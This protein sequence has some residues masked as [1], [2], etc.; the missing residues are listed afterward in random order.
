MVL[1]S[2]REVLSAKAPPAVSAVLNTIVSF[3]RVTTLSRRRRVEAASDAGGRVVADGDIGEGGSDR[4][5]RKSP[6]PLAFERLPLK[7]EDEIVSGALLVLRKPPPLPT[8]VL[9]L[10]ELAKMFTLPV[11]S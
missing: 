1:I 10:N 7:V 9:P 5:A 6:P 8:A 2:R 4:V 11:P 3:S